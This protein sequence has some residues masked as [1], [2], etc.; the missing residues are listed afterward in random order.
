MNPDRHARV[1]RVCERCGES[2]SARVERVNAGQGRFCSL[3]CANEWQIE[4]GR[5]TW[6]KK[7]GKKYWNGSRWVVHWRDNVG[8]THVQSYPRWWW[9]VHKGV[10]PKNYF[11]VLK[12]NDVKNINPRNFILRTKKEHSIIRGQHGAGTPKPTLAGANSKWWRGGSSYEGYP[13][14]FSHSLKKRIKIRDNYTC[15]CCTS[16]ME[17][18]ELDVHHID[19]NVKHNTEDNLVTVCKSCHKAIHGKEYK[20]NK[21]ILKYKKL[22]SRYVQ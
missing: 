22:L 19:C 8:K 9:E 6:G 15:Q 18:E 11:V 3:I 20:V 7:N 12:D 14:E 10:V 1:D 13:T 4:E 5:K 16:K 21:G 17:T 2:F